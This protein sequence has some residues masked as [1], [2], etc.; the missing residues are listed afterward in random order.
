MNKIV[1][2]ESGFKN[3]GDTVFARFGVEGFLFFNDFWSVCMKTINLFS[4]VILALGV[5]AFLMGATGRRDNPITVKSR[6]ET[7]TTTDATREPNCKIPV[8]V[9]CEV[10]GT[11]CQIGPNT[12]TA[13]SR[14][15]WT[16]LDY[17]DCRKYPL[18]T[19]EILA[20]QPP[21]PCMT[22]VAYQDLSCNNVLCSGQHVVYNCLTHP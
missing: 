8:E 11:T 15:G 2:C 6:C 3:V 9:S 18:K 20:D 21:I 10:L 14:L 4:I 19:C 13:L 5:S 12:Y 1:N 7:I 16:V 17:S 22:W